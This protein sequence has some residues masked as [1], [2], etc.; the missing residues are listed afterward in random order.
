MRAAWQESNVKDQQTSHIE[1]R[2]H[3]GLATPFAIQGCRM[4]PSMTSVRMQQ[5]KVVRRSLQR[6]HNPSTHTKSPRGVGAS[7]AH[8]KQLFGSLRR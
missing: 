1:G 3:G 8:T 4:Q 5:R 2:C 6:K 7:G